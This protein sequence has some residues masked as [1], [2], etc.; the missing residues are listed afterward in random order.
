M[1]DLPQQSLAAIIGQ[2]RLPLLDHV[3]AEAAVGGKARW[4]VARCP[5]ENVFEALVQV[6]VTER[7]ETDEGVLNLGEKLVSLA[8]LTVQTVQSLVARLRL[9]TDVVV[10]C[11]AWVPSNNGNLS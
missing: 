5:S 7:A 9:D 6:G 10:I 8:V 1:Q 2:F 3:Q 11:F 4:R